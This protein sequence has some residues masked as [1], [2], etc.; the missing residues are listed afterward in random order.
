[1]YGNVLSAKAL[2]N[3]VREPNRP[4]HETDLER[5]KG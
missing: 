2:V 4:I 1:M 3:L 5:R